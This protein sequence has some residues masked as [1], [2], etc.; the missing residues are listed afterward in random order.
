MG[1]K[2]CTN[3]DPLIWDMALETCSLEQVDRLVESEVKDL[4]VAMDGL[5]KRV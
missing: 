5:H 2:A 1:Q 3:L 4:N